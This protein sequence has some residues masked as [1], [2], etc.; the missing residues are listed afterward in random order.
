MSTNKSLHRFYFRIAGYSFT[1]L[2]RLFLR[3]FVGIMLLQY[4][5]RQLS[6]SSHELLQFNIPYLEVGLSTWLV[7]FV[8]IVCAFF[9][10]IGLFTRLALI[11]PFILMICSTTQLFVLYSFSELSI[12][13]MTIPFLYMGV[14]FFMMLVGPG[15]ISVDYFYSLFLISRHHNGKEEHLEEV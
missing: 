11:P 12:S 15:K 13:L 10:M 2:G 4:G 5:V 9:I 7:I 14:F 6:S 8:E 1:N 3:L